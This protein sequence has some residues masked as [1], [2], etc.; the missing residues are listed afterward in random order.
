MSDFASKYDMAKKVGVA[1]VTGLGHVMSCAASTVNILDGTIDDIYSVSSAGSDSNFNSEAD[2][3]TWT[4]FGE[5]SLTDGTAT[6][7]TLENGAASDDSGSWTSEEETVDP[8]MMSFD[9]STLNGELESKA[10][11]ESSTTGGSSFGPSVS[12]SRTHMGY[13]TSTGYSS[14]TSTYDARSKDS[15]IMAARSQTA[16]LDRSNSMVQSV[17]SG[18]SYKEQLWL[19]AQEQLHVMSHEDSALQQDLAEFSESEKRWLIEAESEVGTENIPHELL[20]KDFMKRLAEHERVLDDADEEAEALAADQLL[21]LKASEEE[22]REAEAE[23]EAERL[24]EKQRAEREAKEKRLAEEKRIEE[25]QQIAEALRASEAAL[26]A[27]NEKLAKIEVAEDAPASDDG[28]ADSQAFDPPGIVASYAFEEDAPEVEQPTAE[29][30]PV[31]AVEIGSSQIE[32]EIDTEE[33]HA[34]EE[35]EVT[36]QPTAQAQVNVEVELDVLDLVTEEQAEE[37]ESHEE[38]SAEEENQPASRYHEIVIDTTKPSSHDPNIKSYDITRGH[39]NATE[40]TVDTAASWGSSPTSDDHSS[41]L[42]SSGHNSLSFSGHGSMG[43]F[44]QS[45]AM[46]A[47]GL[48]HQKKSVKTLESIEEVDNEKSN[49]KKKNGKV[50][51]GL[52]KLFSRRE[53]NFTALEV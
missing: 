38:E 2:D 3:A 4:T 25:E 21:Q 37:E 33:A 44:G 31:T 28:D 42:S 22:E 9:E 48:Y 53:K 15:K 26:E 11:F 34:D 10:T 49:G 19:E 43:S 8:S 24:E 46:S 16:S 27:I 1:T 35:E 18:V 45:S 40:A 20:S 29:T 17:R 50:K 36:E 12:D 39:S 14:N 51:K 5:H 23:R 13:S 30:E 52:K 41:L 47:D 6:L 32:I 7:N